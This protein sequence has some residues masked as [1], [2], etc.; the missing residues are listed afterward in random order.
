[1]L[2][3]VPNRTADTDLGQTF[4]HT[5]SIGR[6]YANAPNMIDQYTEKHRAKD[7]AD[8]LAI[9]NNECTGGSVP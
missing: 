5:H 1:M 6:S 9:G 4:S 3:S 8:W 2:F 7:A